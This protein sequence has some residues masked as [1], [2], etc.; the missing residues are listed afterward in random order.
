MLLFQ[1]DDDSSEVDACNCLPDC[2]SIEYQIKVIKSN[3]E[4][5]AQWTTVNNVTEYLGPTYYGGLTFSFGDIEYHAL[6]RH[7]N[8][9]TVGFI[10]DVGGL[11]S[12]FLG[13]SVMSFV[14]IFYFFGIRV[15]TEIL[16]YLKQK[17]RV[18]N[19]KIATNL[20]LTLEEINL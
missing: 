4:P 11:L 18:K 15:V 6:K 5:E 19:K 9:G 17:R 7:A 10:S 16:R 3:I 13:V 2:N 8:Y 14:E 12:L 1:I 20:T